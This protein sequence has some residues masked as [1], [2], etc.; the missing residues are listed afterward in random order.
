MEIAHKG[1]CWCPANTNQLLC[2]ASDTRP[3]TYDTVAKVQRLCLVVGHVN[4]RG[5]NFMGNDFSW[6]RSS[7]LLYGAISQRFVKQQRRYVS[8]HHP[9]RAIS[10]CISRQPRAL[11]LSILPCR[12]CPNCCTRSANSRIPPRLRSG[13]QIVA[14]CLGVIRPRLRNWA[15]VALVVGIRGYITALNRMRP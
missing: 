8:R 13:T 15:I 7:P 11:R 5:T 10:V 14:H 4:H 1:C 12:S 6:W 9:P 3:S 2:G